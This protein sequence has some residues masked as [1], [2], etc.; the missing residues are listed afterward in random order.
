[1]T[2]T[3]NHIEDI[4]A[5]TTTDALADLL[6]AYCERYGLPYIDAE[7]LIFETCKHIEAAETRLAALKAHLRW[8]Q[9]FTAQWMAVQSDEDFE[10]AIAARGER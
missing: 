2:D 1:M 6:A 3:H 8:L 4:T 7:S 5:T 10:A 9:T